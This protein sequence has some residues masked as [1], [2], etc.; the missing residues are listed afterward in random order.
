SAWGAG[1]FWL[2]PGYFWWVTPVIGA[3]IL[4]VP[5]SVYTSRASLGERARRWGL[6]VIPEESAAPPELQD[7]RELARAARR[8][9]DA[10]TPSAPRP[11]R[12]LAPALLLCAAALGCRGDARGGVVI[13]LWA[14]GREGEV[15]A[16]LMPGFERRHPGLRVRVQQIPWSAAHEKLMTAY[17]GGAMPAVF[18]AGNTWLPEFAAL[19]ALEPLDDRI[20]RSPPPVRGDYFPGILDTNVIDGVTYGVPW[21]VDTRVLFYR[22]D[23]L[24][25][26]G[27]PDPPRTWAA[28]ADAMARVKARAGPERY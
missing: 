22:R 8:R 21:Y 17:V 11:S 10:L 26:A 7:L 1:L 28:W 24:A 3:L 19:D 13:E 4:S 2:S 12:G 25:E 27:H 18:Q 16:Q 6:F 20:P 14:M 15:V 23:L 9:T 5:L